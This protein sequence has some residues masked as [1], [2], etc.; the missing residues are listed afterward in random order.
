VKQNEA[1][2]YS[3]PKNG[4]KP[5]FQEMPISAVLRIRWDIGYQE[6]EPCLA[7]AD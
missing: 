7:A 6:G 3:Q 4:E 2:N 5:T 1:E